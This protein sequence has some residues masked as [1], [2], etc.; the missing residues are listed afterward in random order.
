MTDH[1]FADTSQ[2]I[3]RAFISTTVKGRFREIGAYKQSATAA[4]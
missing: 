4:N 2:G 1:T 3:T